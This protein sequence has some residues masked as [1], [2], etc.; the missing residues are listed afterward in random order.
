MEIKMALQILT[1]DPNYQPPL[2]PD[3]YAYKNAMYNQP[4]WVIILAV[5]RAIRDYAALY[6][7]T[8]D[9]A[10]IMKDILI[11]IPA[12]MR[13]SPTDI[14][15]AANNIAS[16]PSLKLEYSGSDWKFAL[17]RTFSQKMSSPFP[18][19]LV[20]P[21]WDITDPIGWYEKWY[22]GIY[23]LPRWIIIRAMEKYL[24]SYNNGILSTIPPFSSDE[25]NNAIDPAEWIARYSSYYPSPTVIMQN[26][27]IPVD[28]MFTVEDI[29]FACNYM[30]R[31]GYGVYPMHDAIV[32]YLSERG[33]TTAKKYFYAT[34]PIPSVIPQLPTPTSTT[35]IFV[36]Q[37][38]APVTST[39]DTFI[40]Q[41]IAPVTSTTDTFIAQEIA[42]VTPPSPVPAKTNIFLVVGVSAVI[43]WFLMK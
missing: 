25:N 10:T 24:E 33:Q 7:K 2:D 20:P 1:S 5:A 6:G 36:A 3:Y 43:L 38:I 9:L 13:F 30:A 34:P 15:Y 39:T 40:A 28:I 16:T 41:E 12:Y 14:E 22:A 27:I 17:I 11:I 18:Y 21:D 35:D 42:P 31:Y 32:Q 29:N 19:D 23:G 26:I 4:S 37:E 8:P